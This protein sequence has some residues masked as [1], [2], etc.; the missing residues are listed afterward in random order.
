MK[1]YLFIV[2]IIWQL[3]NNSSA[4]AQDKGNFSYLID[5]SYIYYSLN[6]SKYSVEYQNSFNYEINTKLFYNV[7]NSFS[8]GFGFGYQNKDYFFMF[9][10]PNTSGSLKREYKEKTLNLFFPV[11]Y[12]KIKIKNIGLYI[13][14]AIVINYVLNYKIKV[15]NT[16]GS[17]MVYDNISF[18]KR[19]GLTYRFSI[20]F[21]KSL[22]KRTSIFI[23]PFWNY[24]FQFEK[25]SYWDEERFNL[26]DSNISYG[27]SLGITFY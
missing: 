20:D 27:F 21:V 12:R 25:L 7:S 16:D 17:N 14:N 3:F 10:K 6:S 5:G 1:Y 11:S 22:N 4:N 19:T 18:D 8:I 26:N 23:S 13:N 9:N 15:S 24:K 2:I